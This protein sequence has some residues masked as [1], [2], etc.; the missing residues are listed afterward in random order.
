MIEIRSETVIPL[1]E[2]PK[3]LPGRPHVSSLYRWCQRKRRPL[4]TV[5]IGGRV[6]TSLE[7]LDRFAEQRTGPASEVP[8]SADA[9]RRHA[10]A[11]AELDASG[12]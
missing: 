9:A 6:F 3:H 8:P 5:K 7:A 2:A 10:R 11:E 12:C 4:E 1:A